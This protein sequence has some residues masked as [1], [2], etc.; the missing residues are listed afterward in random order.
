MHIHK[1]C[2]VF[3]FICFEPPPVH[4]D[5]LPH[6][7]NVRLGVVSFLVFSSAFLLSFRFAV[8]QTWCSVCQPVSDSSRSVEL[9]CHSVP[10][11]HLVYHVY[12]EVPLVSCYVCTTVCYNLCCLWSDSK[13]AFLKL[14]VP[15]LLKLKINLY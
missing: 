9:S 10:H 15:Q 1:L 3:A 11:F 5:S 4:S 7:G 6:R 8:T 2:G 12:T 14:C 13:A